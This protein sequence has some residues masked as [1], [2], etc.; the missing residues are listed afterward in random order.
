MDRVNLVD[1]IH[2]L[3]FPQVT[4]WPV[5]AEAETPQHPGMDLDAT[6]KHQDGLISRRQALGHGLSVVEIKRRLRR[7]DWVAVHPG[8]YVNHTGN[9]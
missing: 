1:L 8:V 4:G 2:S 6:T 9:G 7:R 5:A 3:V